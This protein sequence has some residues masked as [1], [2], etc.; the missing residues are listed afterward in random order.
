MDQT[1]RDLAA[2]LPFAGSLP[3]GDRAALFWKRSGRTSEEFGKSVLTQ[4]AALSKA[5]QRRVHNVLQA[6][7]P[8]RTGAPVRSG[9]PVLPRC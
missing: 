7:H 9:A 2:L 8:K 5:K 3:A 4:L 6:T 1:V